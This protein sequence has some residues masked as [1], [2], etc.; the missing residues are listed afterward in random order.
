MYSRGKGL[1]INDYGFMQGG[2]D[3]ELMIMNVFK[4]KVTNK[5]HR[6]SADYQIP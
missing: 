3:Y 1:W 4:G 5:V 2:N 6:L